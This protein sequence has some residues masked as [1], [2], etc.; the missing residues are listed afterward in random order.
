MLWHPEAPA[1]DLLSVLP[2]IGRLLLGRWVGKPT[3]RSAQ[4]PIC[5]DVLGRGESSIVGEE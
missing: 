3:G 5:N 2:T 1:Y 4:F